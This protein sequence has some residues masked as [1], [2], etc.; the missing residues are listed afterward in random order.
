MSGNP[1]EPIFDLEL[2]TARKLRAQRMAAAGADFLMRR[3]GADTGK[4][5]NLA[6]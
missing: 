3:G 2:A 5:E 1:V 4:N 6:R